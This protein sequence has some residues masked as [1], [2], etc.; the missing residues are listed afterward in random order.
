M[1]SPV[2]TIAETIREEGYLRFVML[3]DNILYTNI[4]Y[5]LKHFLR[6][7]RRASAGSVIPFASCFLRVPV[8]LTCGCW[9]CLA[10]LQVR[11]ERDRF[12]LFTDG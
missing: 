9:T 5:L 12:R 11:N 3:H 1:A 4:G 8:I 2:G 7:L 6:T 10:L